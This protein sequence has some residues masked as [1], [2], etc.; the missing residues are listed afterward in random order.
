VLVGAPPEMGFSISSFVSDV[1]ST[2]FKVASSV[3]K[4]GLA[5][6][7]NLKGALQPAQPQ[8]PVVSPSSTSSNLP[9][10]LGGAAAA[11]ILL[12]ALLRRPKAGTS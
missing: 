12:I 8:V 6:V 4:Q 9:L 1:V 2:P 3:A 7:S 5:T 10:I 11:G